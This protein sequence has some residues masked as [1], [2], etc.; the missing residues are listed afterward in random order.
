LFSEQG[1]GKRTFVFLGR[2]TTNGNQRLL[3][4]QTCS[5]VC[6]YMSRSA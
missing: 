5:S 1:N 6:I 3:F 2:Q 4:H